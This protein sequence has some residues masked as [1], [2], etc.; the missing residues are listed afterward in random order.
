M[1]VYA[2]RGCHQ[3]E[4]EN[5]LAAFAEALALGVDGLE[6]DVR[7][8]GSGT[9][10]CFHDWYL[11][12]LTGLSGR[13]NRTSTERLLEL[14][15]HHPTTHRKRPVATL[16]EVLTLVA[17]SVEVILDL[18]QEGVRPNRLEQDTVALLRQHGLDE[19]VTVSSFNPWVLKRV[20][21]LAPEY[22]T[23]LI[24]SSRLG[25]RLFHPDYCDGLH[26]H[27]A[28]LQRRWFIQSAAQYGRLMVWTADQ[29]AMLPKPIPDAVR[30]IITNLPRRWG[31]TSIGRKPSFTEQRHAGRAR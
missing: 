1:R 31:V 30:G 5:T 20:K 16:D 23:A 17:D 8:T 29:R 21:Q 12:R 22:R 24:A 18:K 3:T 15:I 14:S 7:Q 9:L 25:V 10:V 4:P 6:L 26:V 28:L 2:H 27:H 13:L 19:R 11:K